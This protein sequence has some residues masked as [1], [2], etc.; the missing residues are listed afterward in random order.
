MQKTRDAL[1][2]LKKKMK[3]FRK[4]HKTDTEGLEKKLTEVLKEVNVEIQVRLSLVSHFRIVLLLSL[5][6]QALPRW[7]FEWKGYQEDDG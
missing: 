4:V 5:D 2:E 6:P 7:E 1:R 3:E